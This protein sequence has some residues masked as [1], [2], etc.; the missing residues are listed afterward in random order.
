MEPG[1]RYVSQTP[2][3]ELWNEQGSLTA[4][5]LREV[6]AADIKNLLK[7][8][9][10]RFVVADVGDKLNWIPP[11]ECYTFWKSEVSGR[12]AAPSAPVH[13][14]D[15]PGEYCYLASEW[16]SGGGAPIVLLEK[17]H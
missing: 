2:L 12:L 15:F 14:E 1:Q 9:K 10:V 4:R 3:H 5:K 8:G 13:L 17:I 6:D 11:G 16:E 7:A